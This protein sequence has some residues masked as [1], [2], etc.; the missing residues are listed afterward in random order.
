[1]GILG[2]PVFLLGQSRSGGLAKVL[3]RDCRPECAAGQR[4]NPETVRHMGHTGGATGIATGNILAPARRLR[5]YRRRPENLAK[6]YIRFN[7]L[8]ILRQY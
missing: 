4:P 6:L 2:R 1:M 8:I 5:R 3:S 7:Q